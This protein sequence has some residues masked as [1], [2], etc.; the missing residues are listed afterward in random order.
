M[1]ESKRRERDERR[2]QPREP[3]AKINEPPLRMRRR[4]HGAGDGVGDARHGFDNAPPK[5]FKR[6]VDEIECVE[7]EA[8]RD[9][10]GDGRRRGD[11][12]RPSSAR[13]LAQRRR[14]DILVRAP[15]DAARQQQ[16]Q[17]N[18]ENDGEDDGD[19][20][21]GTRQP[22]SMRFATFAARSESRRHAGPRG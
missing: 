3:I 14:R 19:E 6:G 22:L 5:R 17:G 12:R 13:R 11:K 20:T 18:G 15:C 1:R 21:I 16:R 2:H 4:K 10:R 9:D 8:Q 7:R